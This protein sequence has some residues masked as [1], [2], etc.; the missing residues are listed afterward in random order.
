MFSN[1]EDLENAMNEDPV[2]SEL[3]LGSIIPM[4]IEQRMA[5]NN[6]DCHKE[7]FEQAPSSWKQVSRIPEK[8]PRTTLNQMFEFFRNLDGVLLPEP[9]RML[10]SPA[11]IAA[12]E[13][14]DPSKTR[15]LYMHLTSC[16]VHLPPFTC[17]AITFRYL[18]G[19]SMGYFFY[20]QTSE[21]RVY[22]GKLRVTNSEILL[23]LVEYVGTNLGFNA[24]T[25]PS[26][27]FLTNLLYTIDKENFLFGGRIVRVQLPEYEIV[28]GQPMFIV[29]NS[30]RG[31][32]RY[33]RLIGLNVR[34]MASKTRNRAISKLYRSLEIVR[35]QG[36][37]IKQQLC[38]LPGITLSKEIE[39]LL[40]IIN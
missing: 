35:R 3:S 30:L 28:N 16:G 27:I 11:V 38:G 19:I 20:M 12:I 7:D 15:S 13:N 17:K 24:L 23:Q 26:R 36:K 1:F 5:L 37:L 4:S 31:L 25:C 33:D 8:L 22:A 2:V 6:A 34:G 39:E 40:R 14:T 18:A 32:V 21:I 10:L 9:E 29:P